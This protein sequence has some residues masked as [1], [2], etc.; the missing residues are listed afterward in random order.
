MTR[1]SHWSTAGIVQRLRQTEEQARQE[2]QFGE[3]CNRHGGVTP[4]GGPYKAETS[5]S[6]EASELRSEL[7]IRGIY[8]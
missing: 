1:F 3:M 4:G 5:W 2:R 6:S 7:A 8:L